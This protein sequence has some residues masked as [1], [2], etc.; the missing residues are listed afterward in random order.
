MARTIA[1]IQTE[2][3]TSIQNDA[4]LS[5]IN[6]PSATAIWRRWTWVVAV[7]IAALENLYDAF[8]S[9]IDTELATRKPHTLRWYQSK[10]LEF[11]YGS[12]LVEGQDYYDNSSLTPDQ[13]T[14]QQIVVQS[15]ATEEND[16]VIVKVAREV[17]DELEPLTTPQY[18]AVVQYFADVKDAGVKLEVRSFAAD[19]LKLVIDVYYDPLVLGATGARLDGTNATPVKDAAKAFLRDLPFD[20]RFVK[21]YFVDA[22]QA[23]DGVVIPEVRTCQATKFDNPALSTVDVTYQPYSGFLRIY[24]DVDLTLNYIEYV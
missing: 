10:A 17:S 5:G 6:S 24:N 3:I 2:I 4:T 1:Q 9:E 19:K 20:G 23:V 12:D 22:L 8:R 14:A 7:A 16:R 11:Q 15:A 18:D 13:I 21:S